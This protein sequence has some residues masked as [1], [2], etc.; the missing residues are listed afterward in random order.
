MI[1]FAKKKLHI[2]L[3]FLSFGLLNF[4]SKVSTRAI[5]LLVKIFEL[6]KKNHTFRII[7]QEP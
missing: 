2:L 4:V 1:E 3:I 6:E 7:D 5:A